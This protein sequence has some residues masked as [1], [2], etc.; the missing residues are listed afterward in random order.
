MAA[1]CGS[2]PRR[3]AGC[4]PGCTCRSDGLKELFPVRHR[5]DVDL[6]AEIERQLA[7]RLTRIRKRRGGKYRADAD[8]NLREHV[9]AD[10]RRAMILGIA[11]IEMAGTGP[12]MTITVVEFRLSG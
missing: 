11:R 5:L 1:M 9:I 6:R 10:G 2:K 12:A 8:V 4:A 7:G 3:M